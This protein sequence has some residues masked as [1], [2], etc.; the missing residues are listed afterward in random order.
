V[1]YPSFGCNGFSCSAC[2][3][4]LVSSINFIQEDEDQNKKG[5]RHGK[6]CFDKSAGVEGSLT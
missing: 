2:N 6:V 4:G 1:A 5:N 3:P